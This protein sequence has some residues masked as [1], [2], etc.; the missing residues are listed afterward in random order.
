M[1]L[2]LLLLLL[3]LLLVVVVVLGPRGNIVATQSPGA[4]ER[5]KEGFDPFLRK[6]WGCFMI[7][8]YLI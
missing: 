8:H 1:V 7:F 3:V 4:D 6:S 5:W 2:L